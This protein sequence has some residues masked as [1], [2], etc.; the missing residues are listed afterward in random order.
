MAVLDFANR[1]GDKSFDSYA[2]AIPEIIGAELANLHS[3]ALIDATGVYEATPREVGKAIA[4]DAV[5]IGTFQTENNNLTLIAHVIDVGSGEQVASARAAQKPHQDLFALQGEVAKQLAGAIQKNLSP[6]EQ[7][8]LEAATAATHSA[9][10]F[11]NMSRGISYLRQDL[12]QDALQSFDAAIA[13]D[14]R[15]P[16]AHYYRA[17]A[18]EKLNRLDEAI[19]A[20]KA[21]LPGAE[22]DRPLLWQWDFPGSGK[23]GYISAY[24]TAHQQKQYS[25]FRNETWSDF[26]KQVV[27]AETVD[28]GTR[29]YFVDLAEHSVKRQLFNDRHILFNTLNDR[30]YS[31]GKV[32][33]LTSQTDAPDGT[34]S[35]KMYAFS[36]DGARRWTYVEPPEAAQDLPLAGIVG[37]WFVVA[38]P[39]IHRL[40]VVDITT[41]QTR[42]DPNITIEAA[43]FPL[44]ASTTKH[45]PIV[46]FKSKDTYRAVRLRDGKD[47]WTVHG[48]QSAKVSQLVTDKFLIIFEPERRI[49]V[50]ALETGK[51]V[52][53]LAIPQF[54]DNAHVNIA[55]SIPVV[56]ALVQDDVLYVLSQDVQLYTINLRKGT[57]LWHT[58]LPSRFQSIAI[59]G[60]AVYLTTQNNE[61]LVLDSHGSIVRRTPVPPTSVIVRINDD[62]SVVHTTNLPDTWLRGISSTGE[63]VWQFDRIG[64]ES[65]YVKGLVT[66]YSSEGRIYAVDPSTG[67]ELW[68]H[69]GNFPLFVQVVGNRT[70]VLSRD[71]LYEYS[72]GPRKESISDRQVWTALAKLSLEKHDLDKAVEYASRAAEL[73]PDYP[74]LALV[75]AHIYATQKKVEQAGIELARYVNV[76]GTDSKEGKQA[77]AELSREHQLHW[78]SAID[79]DVVGAPLLIGNRIVSVGR[80]V[81][82]KLHLLALDARDGTVVWRWQAE[83]FVASVPGT[84]ENKPVLWYVSGDANDYTAITLSRIDI[85]GVD[86]KLIVKWRKPARI[87]QAWA[88]TADGRVFVATVSADAAMRTVD[89]GI[90]AIDLATERIV[91]SNNV[92]ITNAT[93]QQLG[94]P[95]TVFAAGKGTL[96]YAV[97]SQRTTVLAATGKATTGAVIVDT[98]PSYKIANDTVAE[99]LDPKTGKI[100]ARHPILWRPFVFRIE[101]GA[102]YAFTFDG[103]AYALNP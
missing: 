14:P 91:W 98:E 72:T 79:L 29:L 93:A 41:G 103:R 53:E 54:V 1:T 38:M 57:V 36:R 56:G 74:E 19:D 71:G 62:N 48:I 77:L 43:E 64:W 28:D 58:Q 2:V 42:S 78:Q 81:L 32:T 45:G 47:A 89:V 99:I 20:L 10:A 80:R 50:V 40:D 95:V 31:D 100:M 55:V 34:A 67:A 70:F 101:N 49:L 17:H 90:D 96:T 8:D 37:N 73:D 12:P 87:E 69:T 35:A 76:V 3:V 9:E 60:T 15:L 39:R 25:L 68:T 30:A 86:Q 13:A 94:Q 63:K 7:K 66:A 22:H 4:A 65:N 16:G 61:L 46:M 18:L 5:V 23:H 75:R 44:S 83:R 26:R 33:I 102:F 97:G 11:Q 51:I 21:A 92:K 24:D 85:L 82:D 27:Y 6:A 88:A 84:H 59:H 52:Y